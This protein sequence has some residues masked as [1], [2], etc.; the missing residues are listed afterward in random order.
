MR[1]IVTAFALLVTTLSS[2]SR[3]L[4]IAV[5]TADDAH[6]GVFFGQQ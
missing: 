3:Q 2:G 4:T 6:A 5:R 1:S